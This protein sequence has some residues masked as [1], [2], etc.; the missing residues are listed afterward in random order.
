[1]IE[2]R[3]DH[4]VFADGI[5][6]GPEIS[7]CVSSGQGLAEVPQLSGYR[8]PSN[9]MRDGERLSELGPARARPRLLGD[10]PIE[11]HM[12]SPKI[13]AYEHHRALPEG[14]DIDLRRRALV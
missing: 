3:I 10:D 12:E 13:V 11:V 4:K 14:S 7:D 1:M 8:E 5:R 6:D 2:P 9:W